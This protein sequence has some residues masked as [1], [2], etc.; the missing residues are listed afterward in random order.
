[1][2]L[3]QQEET[4]A[5]KEKI[6]SIHIFRNKVKEIII[7]LATTRW[8]IEDSLTMRVILFVCIQA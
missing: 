8:N 6:R 7:K 3:H 1:M 5:I 4:I 2:N